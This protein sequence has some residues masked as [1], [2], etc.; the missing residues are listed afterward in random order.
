M[1]QG[2]VI[3]KSVARYATETLLR[4]LAAILGVAVSALSAATFVVLLGAVLIVMTLWMVEDVVS[5]RRRRSASGMS[6]ASSGRWRYLR[7]KES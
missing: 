3:V 7:R 6:R 2:V 1:R 5:T 4:L